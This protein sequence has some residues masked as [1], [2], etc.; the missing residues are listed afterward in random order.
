MFASTVSANKHGSAAVTT[1]ALGLGQTIQ[2]LVPGTISENRVTQSRTQPPLA[3]RT[4]RAAAESLGTKGIEYSM[5]LGRPRQFHG[6]SLATAQSPAA[7]DLGHELSDDSLTVSPEMPVARRLGLGTLKRDSR[8]RLGS[9]KRMAV[10]ASPSRNARFATAVPLG[11]HVRKSSPAPVDWDAPRDRGPPEDRMQALERQ[12]R[13]LE[14]QISEHTRMGVDLRRELFGRFGEVADQMGTVENKFAT[15][16][17][18]LDAKII[19][20][21]LKID[22]TH[23]QVEKAETQLPADGRMVAEG[24]NKLAAEIDVLKGRQ[25]ETF[26]KG[27]IDDLELMRQHVILHEPAL[28]KITGGTAHF[29][30][31]IDSLVAA[32]STQRDRVS[33]LE[34]HTA[35][36]TSS[37]EA[38]RSF[39]EC[40]YSGAPLW[41]PSLREAMATD[42]LQVQQ[43]DFL[44]EAVLDSA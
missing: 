36:L 12:V 15:M 4:T 39:Q 1:A 26:T 37:I 11:R 32:M 40:Q 44:S 14:Q 2:A 41:L 9:G 43:E 38:L 29:Q 21:D 20:I 30:M 25:G 19:E 13:Q 10:S 18:A 16:E 7:S 28:G 31:V 5:S 22:L 8:A 42:E 35:V 34:Q 17:A 23:R 24:F 27:M 33:G 3:A 6:A